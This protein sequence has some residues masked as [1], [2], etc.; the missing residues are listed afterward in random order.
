MKSYRENLVMRVIE[1]SEGNSWESAVEEWD[2][3]D[4]EEDEDHECSCICGKEDLR[5]LFTIRNRYNQNV[6]FPIGSRCIRK[7]ERQDMDEITSIHESLFKLLHA[8][9]NR[10]RI[11]LTSEFFSRKLLRYM[12]DNDAF[13]ATPYN[14]GDSY[15]DYQFMLDMFNRRIPLSPRQQSKVN[16]IILNSI[17]PYLESILADK[18]H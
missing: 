8:L 11:E 7:F 13:Q 2:I 3:V 15:N 9:R 6:L 18:I 16:A 14:H 4:C 10:E 12:Y 17:K 5:F 1:A